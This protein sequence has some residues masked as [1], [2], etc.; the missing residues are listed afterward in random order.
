MYSFTQITGFLELQQVSFEPQP[1]SQLEILTSFLPGV[2][3]KHPC[4]LRAHSYAL[5]AARSGNSSAE[6]PLQAT[7]GHSLD[8][9]ILLN[10]IL[11]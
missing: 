9:R 3:F 2:L 4:L 6:L 10:M 11:T 7:E 8:Q 5:L 1:S